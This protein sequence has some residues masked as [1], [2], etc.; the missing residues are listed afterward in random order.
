MFIASGYGRRCATFLGCLVLSLAPSACSQ[1]SG[2]TIAPLTELDP[3]VRPHPARAE[4]VDVPTRPQ[5]IDLARSDIKPEAVPNRASQLPAHGELNFSDGEITPGQLLRVVAGAMGLTPVSLNPAPETPIIEIPSHMSVEAALTLLDNVLAAAGQELTFG[6]GVLYLQNSSGVGD[7]RLSRNIV[8]ALRLNFIDNQTFASL[9]GNLIGRDRLVMPANDPSLVVYIGPAAGG[10]SLEELRPLLDIFDLRNTEALLIPLQRRNPATVARQVQEVLGGSNGGIPRVIPL[11]Q[12]HSLLLVT[13]RGFDLSNVSQLVSAI[14]A[15]TPEEAAP[16]RTYTPRY[17]TAAELVSLLRSLGGAS[18][19]AASAPN[20]AASGGMPAPSPTQGPAAAPSGASAANAAPGPSASSASEPASVLLGPLSAPPPPASL[21]SALSGSVD[22]TPEDDPSSLRALL[23]SAN[24]DRQTNR[25]IFAGSEADF[26]RLRHAL[27]ALD[28]GGGQIMVEAVIMQVQL[29]DQL[30]YGVQYAL[31]N[32]HIFGTPISL[33]DTTG[34]ATAAGL[35]FNLGQT[36]SQVIVSALDSVT[37][38]SVISSPKILTVSGETARFHFG[39]SVPVL[40]STLTTSQGNGAAIANQI[41]YRD[42][43][44]SLL[45]TPSAIDNVTADLSIQQVLSDLSST[46]VSG[47]SSPVFDDRQINTHVRL[48]FGDTI[49]LGGIIEH[50]RND[51][52]TGIPVLRRIPVLGALFGTTARMG[53]R[54]EYVLLLTPRLFADESRGPRLEDALSLRFE[55]LQAMWD[56]LHE[57]EAFPT[58]AV[59]RIQRLRGP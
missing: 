23:A 31:N 29:N 51:T 15:G 33:T 22:A 35:V 25:I 28:R 10:G 4:E 20:D 2:P 3:P 19:A 32:A 46:T 24:V 48:R 17:R 26:T 12:R 43:G 1:S 53:A 58:D 41:E 59:R 18:A 52:D 5:R 57:G 37:N 40:A 55:R 42:T 30:Q 45:V 14:D 11:P 8:R 13:P 34:L 50:D 16:V 56:Q 49:M 38:V 27:D 54:Y 39:S 47:V 36:S 7:V 9:A 44:V 21:R 6:D